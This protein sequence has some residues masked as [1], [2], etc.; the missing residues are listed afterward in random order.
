MAV[1]HATTA[2]LTVEEE[3][4]DDARGAADRALAAARRGTEAERRTLSIPLSGHD[5]G[6]GD[7]CRRDPLVAQ[8]LR[9]RDGLQALRGPPAAAGAGAGPRGD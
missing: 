1:G 5:P 8:S 3:R 2:I 4:Q 9:I 7:R 6:A